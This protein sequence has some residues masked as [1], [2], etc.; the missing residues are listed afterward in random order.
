MKINRRDILKTLFIGTLGAGT[1]GVSG[2]KTE[3]EAVT[4]DAGNGNGMYGRTDEEKLHD[5]LIACEPSYFNPQEMSALGILI[6]I[7]LPADDVSGSAGE[8]GVLEFIDFIVKDIE[9]HKL[10]LRT[11]L[12]WMSRESFSRF[13]KSFVDLTEQ[14]MLDIINDIAYPEETKPENKAGEKFFT[15]LRNLTMTGFYTSRMGIKD[16]GYVGN[17][18]NFWDGVPADELAKHGFTYD[19]DLMPKYIT[20]EKSIQLASWDDQGNLI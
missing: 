12:G 9:S 11:G 3:E 17:R 13:D 20:Q 7:I 16:I 8:A 4:T 10:P 19:Q 1:I 2:C 6:D 18:P 5:E 14:E 15:L